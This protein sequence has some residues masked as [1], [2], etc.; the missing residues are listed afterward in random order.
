MLVVGQFVLCS[1]DYFV[2]FECIVDDFFYD[3]VDCYCLLGCVG[4]WFDL[5]GNDWLLW[6]VVGGYLFCICVGF[7]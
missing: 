7:V 1:I 5:I 6:C 2:F 3:F 4:M